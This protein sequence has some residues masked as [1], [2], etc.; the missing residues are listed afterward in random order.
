MH[1][2]VGNFN[3]NIV[4]ITNEETFYFTLMIPFVGMDDTG[5]T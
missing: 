1:R 5:M 4:E 3:V 2:I